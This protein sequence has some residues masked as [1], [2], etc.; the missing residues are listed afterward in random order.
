MKHFLLPSL[1][2]RVGLGLSNNSDSIKVTII[3]IIIWYLLY[4]YL[5]DSLIFTLHGCNIIVDNN[6]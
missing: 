1:L 4:I 3:T 5:S 6:T 2:N